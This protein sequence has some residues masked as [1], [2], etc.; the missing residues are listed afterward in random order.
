MGTETERKFLVVGD[1]WKKLP[2]I[3]KLE[4]EQ[5]YLVNT[6]AMTVRVRV[7]Q[8]QAYLTVKYPIT[9]R[10]ITR[11]EFEYEVPHADGLELI[12]QCPVT[13]HKTRHVLRDDKNQILEVDIFKKGLRGLKMVEIELPDEKEK[14]FVHPWFGDDVTT[15]KHY[16]NACLVKT[17][18]KK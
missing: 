6:P 12:K 18:Q 10:K 13:L 15:Q 5:G 2:L 17:L 16:Q 7:T 4:I 14:V 1:G 11:N 8:D 3:K 9:G